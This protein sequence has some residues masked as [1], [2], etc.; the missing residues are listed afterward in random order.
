MIYKFYIHISFDFQTR[1]MNARMQRMGSE[2]AFQRMNIVDGELMDKMEMNAAPEMYAVTL[3]FR[4][5]AFR[6]I[7]SRLL[8]LSIFRLNI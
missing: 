7:D 8:Q 3:L 5:M 6:N 2:G 4:V 1:E